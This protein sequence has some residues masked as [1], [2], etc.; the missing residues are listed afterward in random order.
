MAEE[1]PEEI[2]YRHVQSDASETAFAWS[3]LDRRSSQIALALASRGLGQ[4]DRLALAIRNSPELLLST[5]AAWKLGAVPIPIRWDLPEWELARLRQVIEP[6]IFI[7]A[8]DLG[9]IDA[10]TALDVPG[11]PDA[12]SP[13]LFGICSSGSTG[14]PKVILMRGSSRLADP[15]RLS[16]M[17]ANWRP[18]PR[19]QQILI[20]GPMYHS[21][22]IGT[23]IFMFGGDHV[24]ILEGFDAAQVADV[25][26]RHRI[27]FFTATPTM[28]KRIADRPDITRRDLSSIEWILQ[29][30]APMPPYLVH[31]WSEL[32]GADRIVMAYAMSESFGIVAIRADE[33]MEHQGSTGRPLQ[34]TEVRILDP[35]GEELTAGEAGEVYLRSRSHGGSSYLGSPQAQGTE[36]GFRSVGDI[37]YLDRDGYL[38]LLDRRVDM[39]I[40]GGANVF[41]AE[42]ENALIEHPK[43]ADI[44]VIGLQDPEWGRRVHALIA[45][46]DRADPPTFEEIRSYAKGRLAAYKVPKSIETVEMIPRSEASKINRRSLVEARGG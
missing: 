46:K 2:V 39:I 35:D 21:S 22:G 10:S 5:F 34:G 13:H 12:E 27:S 44:V 36:D 1:F 9:W 37:G 26:E 24:T 23:L 20:P 7:Q 33:W 43:V 15:S 19:P 32:V 42:V 18:V 29:S 40:S 16:P 11:L 3:E 17:M 31:R 14:S 45:P 38:Y 8:E 4:G 41:P 25:I 6:K 30:S 28:L